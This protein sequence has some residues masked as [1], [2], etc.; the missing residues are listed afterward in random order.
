MDWNRRLKDV[1]LQLCRILLTQIPLGDLA[2]RMTRVIV[3]CRLDYRFNVDAMD[4]LAKH[5][6]IQ[7]NVYDQNLAMLIDSGSNFEVFFILV[8]AVAIFNVYVN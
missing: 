7:M 6:L 5:M 3:D 2:R 8:L 4:L 1:F